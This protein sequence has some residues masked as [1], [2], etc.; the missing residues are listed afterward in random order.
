MQKSVAASLL[1]VAASP[2]VYAQSAS[3]ALDSAWVSACSEAVPGTAF[4]DRCQEILNSGPGSGAR[5]S[6]AAIGNNLEVFA[7][8][9]RMMMRMARQRGRAAARGTAAAQDDFTNDFNFA[10]PPGDEPAQLLPGDSGWSFFGT[11]WAAE[12]EHRD[13]GFERGYDQSD[14]SLLVG[15][16]YRWNARWSALIGLHRETASVDFARGTGSMDSTNDQAT[17]ALDYAGGR[18][19]SASLLFGAGSMDADLQ[20]EINYTLVLNAGQPNQRRVTIA[21]RGDS[22]NSADTRSAELDF[23][24]D[25]ALGAWS[26]HYGGSYSWERTDI[27]RVA[28]NNDVGLDFLIVRQRVDSQQ[29]GLELQVARAFSA[30]FG[31][32]QPYARLRW[33][34]EYGDDPHRVFALFRGGRK[35]FRLSFM[36]GEPDRDFGEFG[37]GVVGVFPRGWSMYAGWQHTFANDLLDENRFDFGWRREF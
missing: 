23:G 1:L 30:S 21:S 10:D 32:W 19:F 28:E 31:V 4:Y 25:R 8:Q 6:A 34:H 12:G 2:T 13:T 20:R 14:R 18:G 9:A 26:F 16:Q 15:L 27:A 33:L 22:S 24:W 37:L 17:V 11:A 29:L 5:R 35:V 3:E 36:T 7:S